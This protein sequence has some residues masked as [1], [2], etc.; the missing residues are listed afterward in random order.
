MMD[1]VTP[2]ILGISFL[3]L[4][5][6]TIGG[7]L[8]A[9]KLAGDAAGHGSILIGGIMAA[10]IFLVQLTLYRMV[11]NRLYFAIIFVAG[12]S[13][14]LAWFMFSLFMPILWMDAIPTYAKILLVSLLLLLCVLNF[15][16]GKNDFVHKW[17][18]G[19]DP[20]RIGKL[21]PVKGTIAWEKITLSLKHEPDL[22]IPGLPPKF[23]TPIGV[24][25]VICMLIGLNFRTDFPVFSAFAWGIPSAF[26]TSFVFQLMGYKVGEAG[27][28]REI[29]AE[30]KVDLQSA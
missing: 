16:K 19:P 18:A 11:R 25:L 21:D 17:C 24:T 22:Y 30:L 28:V 1:K 23:S 2:T 8:L 9:S 15:F 3:L 29:Q 10:L 12:F 13:L 7:S 6:S 26:I 5:A 14:T 27:K 4:S 20:L